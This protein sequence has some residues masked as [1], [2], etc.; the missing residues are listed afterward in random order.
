MDTARY[1][2]GLF[3][4]L[5]LPPGLAWWFLVH[6]FATFWR[7]VGVRGTLT[8]MTVFLTGGVVGLWFV[9][10]PLM[11]RDFGFQWPMAAFAVPC[12]AG[13]IVLAV[14]RKKHLTTR[15]LAGVPE[16]SPSDPGTLLTK[17]V[18][19]T[20][21]HPRYVEIVCAVLAYALFSNHL[22]PWLVFALCFPLLHAIVILE[23]RELTQRFGDEYAVYRRRVPRYVPRRR[24]S[25]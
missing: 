17:G 11:G 23:E 4:V 6:P 10:V 9:R 3:I 20:I 12:L 2:F 7:R 5:C 21:R 16:V 14:K 24:G 8:F 1:V 19:G 25:R 22:G 13:A 15:I 18:Y